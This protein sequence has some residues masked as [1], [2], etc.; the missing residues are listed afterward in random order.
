MMTSL[1][2][3]GMMDYMLICV[4]AC[5]LIGALTGFL[6]YSA[7]KRKNK[8]KNTTAPASE[9]NVDA[10]SAV[11]DIVAADKL[12]MSRN[13]IYS[14]G[15]NGQL[16]TG[17]YALSNADSTAGKFNVRLNGLVR[18][19]VNGDVV[20]LADGDTISPVSGSVIIRIVED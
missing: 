11:E 4:C 13:V 8:N 5:A 16:K 9:T 18:E 3:L 1:L 17:E 7:S 14:A 12:V 2:A 10:Q 20:M 19:Y 6:V 15:V